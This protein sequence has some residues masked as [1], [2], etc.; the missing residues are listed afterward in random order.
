MSEELSPESKLY[1]KEEIEKVRKEVKEEVEK[2]KSKATKTFGTV[3]IVV[4]LL[5][6]LGVWGL[7]IKYIDDA[8]NK[9][10][11]EKGIADLLAKATTHVQDINDL[12][13]EAKVSHKSIEDMEKDLK[14]RLKGHTHEIVIDYD[15]QKT[16]PTGYVKKK[17][18]V[19][20]ERGH[21]ITRVYY[22]GEGWIFYANPITIK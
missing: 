10:L 16:K 15:Q 18:H 2:V 6:G 4:G 14:D 7:A 12:V 22:D 8:V 17:T 5:T 13:V 20:I 3:V 9:G 21:V 19:Q 11:E 1:V